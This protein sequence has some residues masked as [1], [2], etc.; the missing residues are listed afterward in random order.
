LAT[1]DTTLLIDCKDNIFD[2]LER[3]NFDITSGGEHGTMPTPM[4]KTFNFFLQGVFISLDLP[5]FPLMNQ[6][7]TSLSTVILGVYYHDTINNEDD[8]HRVLK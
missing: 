7:P 4:G 3:W 2:S 6:P 1:L 5:F 8:M